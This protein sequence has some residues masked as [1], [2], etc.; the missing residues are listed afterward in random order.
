MGLERQGILTEQDHDGLDAFLRRLLE[1]HKVGNRSAADAIADLTHLIA[2]VDI[3]SAGE[4]RSFLR[5]SP[6]SWGG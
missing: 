1:A 4:V 5:D 6:E 3:G 2:A